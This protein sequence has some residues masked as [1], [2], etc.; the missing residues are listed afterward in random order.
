MLLAHVYEEQGRGEAVLFEELLGE[1][2]QDQVAQLD[3]EETVVELLA[4]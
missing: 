1:F 3:E 2:V 4:T